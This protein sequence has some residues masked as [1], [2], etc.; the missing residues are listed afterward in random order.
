[1]IAAAAYLI[2]CAACSVLAFVRHP[3]YG[4]Y[5]YLA[6]FYVHP[7][8]RWWNYM[9]P[10]VRWSL[11][12]A[13][14][15]ILAV[16]LHRGRLKQ[17]PLWLANTP[18]ILLTAFAI[19]MVLQCFWAL[20]L[21]TH[22]EGA[23]KFLKYV[24][25]FWL[26]YRLVDTPEMLRNVLFFHAV[27]CTILG[28]LCQFAG[29]E[30]GRLDGVGGPGLDDANTLG[31]Y[32]ATGVVAAF[33]VFLTSTGWRRWVS[34]LMM[35]ISLNGFVLA[36]SR[37]AFLGIVAGMLVVLYC[38]SREHRRLF[39][40]M[41]MVGAV[42]FAIIVDKTFVDRMFTIGDVVED[43]EDADVSARSRLELYKAQLHMAADYPMGAGYRGTATLSARYLDRRWLA[44][45]N[46]ADDPEAA[47]TSHNTL[48]SAL[49]EQGVLGF[50]LFLG[51]IVW[52]LAAASRLRS[53]DKRGAPPMTVTLGAATCGALF[54]VFVAGSA[55][56][57]LMAEVQFW[58]FAALVS[59]LRFDIATSAERSHSGLQSVRV[60]TR[61]PAGLGS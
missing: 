35:V 21:E 22:A 12:S 61:H 28:V 58:L 23:S 31:M 16:V 4:F 5:F 11:I 53:M 37:G 13:V 52:M 41:A 36:N 8:S 6:A 30:G 57:Y 27:G 39:W 10:G 17:K 44:Q 59:A 46:G 29:R 20:D 56:D 24:I 15:A 51:L 7:P 33:G 49:V 60:G 47:R 3:I 38:K 54:V 50:M 26:V 42:G 40:A 2:F 34:L 32:L 19:L 45:D 25:A 1:M 48:M 18:A 55:T 43:S 9:M 14:I